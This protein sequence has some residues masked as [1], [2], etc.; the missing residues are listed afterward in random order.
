[1]VQ[2]RME[3]DVKKILTSFF[4]GILQQKKMIGKILSFHKSAHKAKRLFKSK[5]QVK[6]QRIEG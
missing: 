4:K 6:D 2:Y 3:N 1:M 5:I